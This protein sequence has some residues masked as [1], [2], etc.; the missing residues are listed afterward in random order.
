MLRTD[1][2]EQTA[3]DSAL[4]EGAS[5]ANPG[6]V[7]LVTTAEPLPRSQ[8]LVRLSRPDPSFVTHL[9]ATAEQVPQTRNHRRAA[10][11]DALTAYAHHPATQNTG[12]RTRQII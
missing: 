1:G 7:A 5:D 9:L 8:T 11:A 2:P 10:Q 4:D 6:C 3:A 12:F